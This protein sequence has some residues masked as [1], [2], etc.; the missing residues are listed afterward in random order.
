MND[1][2]TEELMDKHFDV[3]STLSLL[4]SGH[5]V[6]FVSRYHAAKTM[7]LY[8]KVFASDWF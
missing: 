7:Q 1:E 3:R 4:T 8:M 2:V 5:A 6:K